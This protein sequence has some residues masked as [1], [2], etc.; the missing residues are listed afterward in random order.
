MPPLAWLPLLAA[1]LL[2]GAFLPQAGAGGVRPVTGIHG[3]AKDGDVKEVQR[4][5]KMGVHPDRQSQGKITALMW[6]AAEGHVDVARL[7]VAAGADPSL[8]SSLGADSLKLAQQSIADEA[9]K[10]E[11]EVRR[12]APHRSPSLDRAHAPQPVHSP[13]AAWRPQTILTGT[14]EAAQKVVDGGKAAAEAAAA[15]AAATVEFYRE[16]EEDGEQ[17]EGEGAAAGGGEDTDCACTP[18]PLDRGLLGDSSAPLR[19]GSKGRRAAAMRPTRTRPR[20]RTS[21]TPSPT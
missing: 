9:L 14:Q 20:C 16:D 8:Q 2:G 15:A 7:L 19:Q 11:M 1:A 13:T 17:K 12:P 18:L 10:V 5:L 4:L 21:S 6:A 3:A